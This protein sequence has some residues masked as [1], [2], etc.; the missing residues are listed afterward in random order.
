[1]GSKASFIYTNRNSDI[2]MISELL[3][4]YMVTAVEEGVCSRL[5]KVTLNKDI[6]T[7]DATGHLENNKVFKK[8][9]QFLLIEG[10]EKYQRNIKE[11]FDMNHILYS[12]EELDLIYKVKIMNAEYFPCN[13]IF[14]N[15]KYATIEDINISDEIEDKEMIM[16]D[17]KKRYEEMK[18]IIHSLTA[19][20]Y[21]PDTLDINNIGEDYVLRFIAGLHT[22][23]FDNEA[24]LDKLGG[25]LLT[26]EEVL[27]LM[28]LW[29][30]GN[31]N[32]FYN[33]EKLTLWLVASG[34][35][36]YL[37]KLYKKLNNYVIDNKC[38]DLLT[39]IKTL[40]EKLN[41]TE[42]K[43]AKCELENQKY[44]KQRDKLLN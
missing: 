41:N 27:E 22:I 5:A 30:C 21:L 33:D 32:D 3:L 4:D 24:D 20:M 1:M 34:Q 15:N 9:K 31:E 36:T 14:E 16:V 35:I 23:A 29:Y 43:L 38:E 18:H 13:K 8:G 25:D 11:L 6:K 10:V 26:K 44:M 12:D 17:I 42:G 40:K 28:Y 37:I 19:Y 2:D 39:E 7:L